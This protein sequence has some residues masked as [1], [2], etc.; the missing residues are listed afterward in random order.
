MAR[1][2]QFGLFDHL[3]RREGESLEALYEGRLELLS[4]ADAGPYYGYHL[5]EHHATPLGMAPSPNLFLAAAS[6]RTRRLRLGTL[7]YLLP[8]YAP[9]RLVEEICMLDQLTG[10]RLDVGIGS[11][12]SPFEIGHH[13]VDFTQS[14]DI[15]DEVLEVILKG[16]TH[17]RLDHRGEHFRYRDV[18]MVLQ[19]KQQPHPPL[20]YGARS[21][22]S[23]QFAVERGINIIFAGPNAMVAPLVKL[24]AA[25]RQEQ[26]KQHR[27]LPDDDDRTSAEPFVG[28]FRQVLVADTDRQAE[29]LA[30]E[31]YSVFYRNIMQLWMENNVISTLIAPDYD[32]AV[33]FDV[34]YAG[35]PDT[36]TA[37][38]QEYFT[39]TGGNYLALE[40]AWGS[41]NHEQSLRSL[42]LLTREVLPTFE[43]V[44]ISPLAENAAEG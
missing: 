10:G 33:H 11:G 27:P 35:S 4:A 3:E 5:A 13:G 14:R 19:P 1:R 30:R 29:R 42:E 28:A 23:V 41:L 2:V 24:Q 21:E 7:V 25:L 15:Y 26:K 34:L 8:L 20:W 6:Q 43:N 38:L 31:S 18:P 16:L 39:T 32:A 9:L 17:P 44:T 22:A 12:I 37:Q 36:V 40:V